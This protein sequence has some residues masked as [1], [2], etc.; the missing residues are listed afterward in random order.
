MS[1]EPNTEE[2]IGRDPSLYGQFQGTSPTIA[3]HYKSI[4]EPSALSLTAI[5]IVDSRS[6]LEDT[7][8]CLSY[9]AR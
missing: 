4:W 9:L 2:L 7:H 1:L 3:V 5:I 6:E 8:S